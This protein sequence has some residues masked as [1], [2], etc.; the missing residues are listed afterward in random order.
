MKYV[1][2][3]MTRAQER[4]NAVETY[5]TEVFEMDDIAM[6]PDDFKARHYVPAPLIK[7]FDNTP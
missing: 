3:A 6:S 2:K 4:L 1:A 5:L 7:L